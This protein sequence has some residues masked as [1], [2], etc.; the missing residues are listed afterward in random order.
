MKIV[1]IFE[2][3][4]NYDLTRYFDMFYRIVSIAQESNT[5][6]SFDG[7]EHIPKIVYSQAFSIVYYISLFD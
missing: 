2:H 5:I 3:K 4:L 1:C 7:E 6:M